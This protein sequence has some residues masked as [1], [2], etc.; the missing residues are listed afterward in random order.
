MQ[1]VWEHDKL[2]GKKYSRRKT[3]IFHYSDLGTRQLG[4]Q[5]FRFK[6]IPTV[7]SI[8]FGNTTN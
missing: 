7:V 8:I 2:D 5:V 3:L 1:L 6:T 4:R